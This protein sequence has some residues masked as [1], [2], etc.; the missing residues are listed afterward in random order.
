MRSVNNILERF[1]QS[2]FFYFLPSTY[3]YVSIGLY[4][5]AI[6]CLLAAL[7]LRALASYAQW[8]LDAHT[9]AELAATSEHDEQLT[10][11]AKNPIAINSVCLNVWRHI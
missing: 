4:M 10:T 5:P 11:Q 2:F 1:H 7:I 6:G 8:A 9:D 3:R